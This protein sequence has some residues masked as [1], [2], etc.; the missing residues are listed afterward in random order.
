MPKSK[1]CQQAISALLFLDTKGKPVLQ[2]D[3]R[4]DVQVAGAGDT[5]IRLLADDE[6]NNSALSPIVFD[7]DTSTTYTYI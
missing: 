3:Y 2:R 5:F 6:D 7:E 1:H 4:G